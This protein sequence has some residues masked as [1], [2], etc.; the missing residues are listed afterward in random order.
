MSGTW[1]EFTGTTVRSGALAMVLTTERDIVGLWSDT[2]NYKRLGNNRWDA[3]R[4]AGEK[5]SCPQ[6][7]GGLAAE[8]DQTGRLVL[9]GILFD[10]D[11]DVIKPESLP[12][13]Q[14]LAAAM[15]ATGTRRYRIEGH[16][17]DRAS[18]EHNLALSQR[19]A[20]A[21]KAWLEHQGIRGDRLT[22]VGFGLTRP[23]MLNDTD[24]GR[25][26]NRRVEVTTQP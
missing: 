20:A 10:T 26:A 18:A 17:D 2:M 8:L 11:K 22:T 24:A 19:R 5:V 3:V 6:D 23:A 4:D 14:D 7:S 21:I 16:T 25:A 1:R 15:K 13:L 9:R 12:V